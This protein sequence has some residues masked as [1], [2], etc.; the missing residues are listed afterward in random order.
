MRALTLFYFKIEPKTIEETA[1]YWYYIEY[2]MKNQILP[3][4]EIPFNLTNNGN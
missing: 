3:M 1:K 4:A 2:L